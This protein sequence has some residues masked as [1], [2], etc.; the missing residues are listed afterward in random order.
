MELYDPYD[1]NLPRPDT[2]STSSQNTEFSTPK[3]AEKIRRISN[4]LNQYDPTTQRFKEGLAKLAKG[5]EAQ[6]T[7]ALQL[8]R[9]FDST[10]AI[11]GARHA[12]YNNSRRHIRITGI[13]SSSQVKEMKYKEYKLTEKNDQ[14]K[15]R[16]KWKK[17]LIEIR[18]HG[19]AKKR[20]RI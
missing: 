20:A 15:T 8:Q 2:P 12:R 17:V 6:A 16:R 11:M 10:Q 7:L 3:T 5:A 13:T 9:E 19:R 18:K 1:D 4:R 14:E